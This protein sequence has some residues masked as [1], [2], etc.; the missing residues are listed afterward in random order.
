MGSAGAA[1]AATEAVGRGCARL[2]ALVAAALALPG[3]VPRAAA[4][5]APETR[6]VTLR[7]LD[8]RDW[9]PGAR[10][11]QVESPLLHLRLPLS[12]AYTLEG[13]VVHDA[14]S[15]ASPLWHDTLSGASGLGVTDHRTAADAKL[16]RYDEG[17]N[18]AI[19]IAGSS[20]RD[21]RS[22]AAS[23]EV[24]R[25]ESDGNR[26]WAFGIAASDDR[27][28]SVNGV[29]TGERRRTF[30]VQ[31]GVTQVWNADVVV[32]SSMSW[33]H[34]NGYYSDPYKPLDTRPRSR[35]VVAWLTRVIRH[36]PG[37]GAV[38]R[39]AYRYLHD[40]FGASSHTLDAELA[41]PLGGGWT[42]APRLRYYTQDAADFYRDP[43]FP[44]GYRPGGYYT[45]DT[46]LSAFGAFTPGLWIE[47]RFADGWSVDGRLEFYRQR[48]AWHL[49]GDGSPGLS[50]LSARWLSVGVTREF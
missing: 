13:T 7:Y 24:N 3:V 14:M 4:E 18:V 28:D 34:G 2:P 10:R 19:G 48:S 22:Q 44:Q 11:M 43:V 36:L 37:S 30:D 23:F 9:Q 31:F 5:A 38:A 49:G 27:I 20:E 50:P 8:Y 35:D 25:N 1:V 29:A 42:L 39:L 15:G 47:K 45:A 40:S 32:T 17:G 46:R 21:Y 26:T 33:S 41:Q 6:V 12:E 16:R